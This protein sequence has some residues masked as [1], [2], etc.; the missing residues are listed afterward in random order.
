[1]KVKV[2]V[3]GYGTIGKRVAWAVKEQDD[4]EIVG[5]TKTRPSYEASTAL[6]EGHPLYAARAEDVDG[7]EGAGIKVAGTLDD[8]LKKVDVIVDCTP[9]GTG[10]RNKDLYAKAGVKAIFQGGEA[11]ELAGISFNAL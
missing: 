11:H 10:E 7:F 6:R 9:G 1:M 4:M 8:L 2:G 3:N 5:V